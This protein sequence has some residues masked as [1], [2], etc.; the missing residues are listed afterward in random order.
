MNRRKCCV[1]YSDSIIIKGVRSEE[2]LLDET[3]LFLHRIIKD[4]P[5]S[6]KQMLATIHDKETLL[7]GKTIMIVDDD[8]R[9]VFAL[10]KALGDLGV[11]IIKAENG[12]KAISLLDN[13]T[14]LV[15]MDIYDAGHG[16]VRNHE[17]HPG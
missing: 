2:R 8:M 16:W 5:E 13:K 14:D 10:S 4:L 9:N 6:K 1:S 15:L 17:T 3:S 11:K 7:K 12:E